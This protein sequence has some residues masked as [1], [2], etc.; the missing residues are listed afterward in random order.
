MQ[1]LTQD[2]KLNLIDL[3][4]DQL[5]EGNI[6]DKEHEQALKNLRG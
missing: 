3:L 4:D 6:S 1:E 5:I 2:E